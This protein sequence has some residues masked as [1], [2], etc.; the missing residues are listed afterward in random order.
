MLA[1][2][3][4]FLW[5]VFFVG[6]GQR[7][8]HQRVNVASVFDKGI[9]GHLGGHGVGQQYLQ[10]EQLAA[11]LG[12]G[13]AHRVAVAGLFHFGFVLGSLARPLLGPHRRAH[14]G[15]PHRAGQKVNAQFVRYRQALGGDG[16]A[17][18]LVHGGKAVFFQ[19]RKARAQLKI[20][21]QLFAQQCLLDLRASEGRHGGHRL[22]EIAQQD[23]DFGVLGQSAR[24]HA[25]GKSTSGHLLTSSSGYFQ[26]LL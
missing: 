21:H 25:K 10:A 8:Q 1:S 15:L 12:D 24:F 9:L 7:P 14:R 6:G 13:T 23:A 2:T 11:H 17:A 4:L 5:S 26:E 18:R 16:P 3:A 22:D 20:V 19:V